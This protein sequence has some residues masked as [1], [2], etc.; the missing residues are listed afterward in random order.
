MKRFYSISRFA[1]IVCALA[2]LT[3]AVNTMAVDNLPFYDTPEFTPRWLA[4]NSQELDGFHQI[5]EFSFVNQD[6]QTVT[7]DTFSRKI[8]VAN[9]FFTTCPGICPMIRSKLSKVQDQFLD[10]DMVS[11]VSHSIRPTTDTTAILQDYA[12]KHGVVSGKWHLLTGDK[13]A[14]YTLAR[15]AYFANEDLGSIQKTNDFLH[16]ENVLLIDNNRHIRGIYNGLNS[17]SMN[18]LIDD[19][20]ALKAEIAG[21]APAS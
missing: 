15:S 14:I 20:A 13:D 12:Q 6:G 7:Q 19:I 9:F 11:L 16:T 3:A 10:D 4:P 17:T 18:H 8:Y 5:P 2:F 21:G 1:N